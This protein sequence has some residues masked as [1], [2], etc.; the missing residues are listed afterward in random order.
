MQGGYIK[1]R[2]ERF[3]GRIPNPLCKE[4]Q[5]NFSAEVSRQK[6]I[7]PQPKQTKLI[8]I[9]LNISIAKLPCPN[10]YYHYWLFIHYG[11]ACA[12]WEQ[13]TCP[14]IFFFKQSDYSHAA[15]FKMYLVGFRP[16]ESPSI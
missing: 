16:F 13:Q 5:G 8:L 12:T 14:E 3:S 1:S 6:S 7:K 4:L 10:L 9:K 2:R 11:R 15:P